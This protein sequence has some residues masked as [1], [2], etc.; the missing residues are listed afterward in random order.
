MELTI[1]STTKVVAI[2]TEGGDMV[3]ARVWEGKTKDGVAVALLVTRVAVDEKAD[4]AAFQKDLE[5]HQ[6]PTEAVV[7]AFPLRMVL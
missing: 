2:T 4:Q 3:P 7:E 1:H 5:E 6:A